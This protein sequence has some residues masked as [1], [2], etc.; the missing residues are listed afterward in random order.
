V[1]LFT[2]TLA[3]RD[4]GNFRRQHNF[5]D[6]S[7]GVALIN[8]SCKYLAGD[9]AVEDPNFL[10]GVPVV[11]PLPA[12]APRGVYGLDAPD[13]DLTESERSI[14]VGKDDKRLEVRAASAPG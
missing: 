9:S 14:T 2:T 1:L 8:E 13:P 3:M 10:C 7:F 6:S 5:Y 11:L 4:I 12:S